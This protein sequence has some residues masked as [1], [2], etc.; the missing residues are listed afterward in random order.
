MSEQQPKRTKQ[1]ILIV[2]DL[3]SNIKTL[4]EI[5]KQ[6]HKIIIASSGKQALD[7]VKD[8]AIDLILLD[9]V[10]PEMDGYEVCSR[11]KKTEVGKKI[12]IIFVTVLSENLDEV[13]ALNAGAIDFITKPVHAASVRAKIKN[14]LLMVNMMKTIEEQNIQIQEASLFR[15][16]MSHLYQ[17]NLREPQERIVSLI[18][19]LNWSTN[20]TDEQI[21]ILQQILKHAYRFSSLLNFSIDLFNIRRNEYFYTPKT[22]NAL[23][24][25]DDFLL[26]EKDY[27]EKNQNP[28]T[29]RVYGKS[30][31][32]E[33]KFEVKGDIVLCYSIVSVVLMNAI[34]CSPAGKNIN[35]L[36]ETAH[37]RGKPYS[38]IKV[39]TEGE[40]L[41]SE[42]DINDSIPNQKI[43]EKTEFD[44]Y[45][46]KLMTEVQKG[47]F[48]IECSK[49]FGSTLEVLIP[50]EIH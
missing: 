28:I 40:V 47:I 45:A 16:E 46:I 18:N 25:I 44:F 17:T 13:R 15:E 12:P 14:H 2:D 49:K 9:I 41:L 35:I 11:L 20:P 31:K 48:N 19:H 34:R 7:I 24:L 26:V 4:A 33:G 37:V 43:Q 30:R 6:D 36:L 10:M 50:T 32:I 29:I 42:T 8:E 23:S 5:L 38:A 22:F 1:T 21:S 27:V 39:H 3:V